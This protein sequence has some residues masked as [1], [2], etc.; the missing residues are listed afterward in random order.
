MFEEVKYPGASHVVVFAR[1]S[2]TPVRE[3]QA[4]GKGIRGIFKLRY[5]P[6]DFFLIIPVVVVEVWAK[7]T[8]KTLSCSA[9]WVCWNIIMKYCEI[10]RIWNKYVYIYISNII[11]KYYIILYT[12]YIYIFACNVLCSGRAKKCLYWSLLI[13]DLEAVGI[14][15][16]CFEP[17]YDWLDRGEPLKD[18]QSDRQTHDL[19]SGKRYK[20]MMFLFNFVHIILHV[21]WCLLY[22]VYMVFPI[23]R[24]AKTC[25]GKV[26]EKTSKFPI[27]SSFPY[28]GN[29]HPNWLIC[30]RGVETTN[31]LAFCCNRSR[32]IQV[33]FL[34]VAMDSGH[35]WSF[36]PSQW[37]A[38]QRWQWQ[39]PP[40]VPSHPRPAAAFQAG[41]ALT[42]WWPEADDRLKSRVARSHETYEIGENAVKH[43]GK[44]MIIMYGYSANDC[45]WM[46]MNLSNRPLMVL[47]AFGS[48]VSRLPMGSSE[49]DWRY[50]HDFEQYYN[51]DGWEPNLQRDKR[52][53]WNGRMALHQSVLRCGKSFVKKV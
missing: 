12:Q 20:P 45:K 1:Y 8:L 43:G 5:T 9:V 7:I 40:A 15:G 18:G 17:Y 31:Q 48:L 11:Y 4:Y 19:E 28:F 6:S 38:A 2:Y 26:I 33:L 23:P 22:A 37:L 36:R 52:Y 21:S 42:R 35:R 51:H 16:S 32:M 13:S 41:W 49:P 30:F 3:F 44:W 39:R 24:S 27:I 34:Q 29:N 53:Q 10:E 46:Y 14:G 50:H 25:W 47:M